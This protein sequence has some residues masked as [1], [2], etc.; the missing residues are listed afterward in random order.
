MTFFFL[1]MLTEVIIL[2]HSTFKPNSNYRHH[3]AW[4]TLYW[5]MNFFLSC[6]F[7][8]LY[9]FQY[10]MMLFLFNTSFLLLIICLFNLLNLIFIIYLFYFI[11]FCQCYFFLCMLLQFKYFLLQLLRLLLILIYI[12]LPQFNSSLIVLFDFLEMAELCLNFYSIFI[13]TFFGLCQK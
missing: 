9:L 10:I 12:L 13:T 5:S 4:I 8:W 1:T 7:L 2:A 6:I 3:S 11:I